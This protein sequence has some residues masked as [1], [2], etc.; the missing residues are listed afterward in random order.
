M[1]IKLQPKG[2]PAGALPYPFFIDEDGFVL[3][4]EFWRGKPYKLLGFNDTPKAGDI[5]LMRKEFMFYPQ[6][7]VAM[8]PV[9]KDATDNWYTYDLPIEAVKVI[10]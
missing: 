3:R 4:Q 6:A 10:N 1:K 2:K 5:K 9:F 8:Y 7:A